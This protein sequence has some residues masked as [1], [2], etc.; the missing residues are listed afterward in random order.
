[1]N[2]MLNSD[3][4]LANLDANNLKTP[5]KQRKL[6]VAQLIMS[7]SDM[8]ELQIIIR[9]SQR[10]IL[11]FK[12]CRAVASSDKLNK[13][14]ANLHKTSKTHKTDTTSRKKHETSC[15]TSHKNS[16]TS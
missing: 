10:T 6:P 15:E 7:S 9:P 4:F 16:K 1:M 3:I 5:I 2:F 12:K 13:K 8:L 11:K 14:L